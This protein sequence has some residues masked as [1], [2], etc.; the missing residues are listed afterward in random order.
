MRQSRVERQVAVKERGEERKWERE[1]PV[2]LRD[3]GYQKS[4]RNGLT[5]K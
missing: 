4:F 5:P 2:N 1:T 3:G